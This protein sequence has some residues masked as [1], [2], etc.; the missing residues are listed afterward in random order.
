[1]SLVFFLLMIRRPPRSTRTDAL[2]PYTTLFRSFRRNDFERDRA[3]VRF[4]GRHAAAVDGRRIEVRIEAAHGNEASLALIVQ[5]ID[6]RR[7]AKRLGDVLVGKLADRVAGQHR[8]HAISG[9][10]PG[11][12]ATEARL[13]ADDQDGGF[14]VPVGAER[15]ADFG[16]AGFGHIDAGRSEEHTSELQSLMRSSYAVF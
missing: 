1:M 2:F 16:G 15:Y 8:L 3:H 13:L 6:A 12:R 7:T 14:L 9:T 11:N 10:L 5:D 4:R